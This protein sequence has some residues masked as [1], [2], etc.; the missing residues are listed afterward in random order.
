MNGASSNDIYLP[1]VL[2]TNM[3][4]SAISLSGFAYSPNDSVFVKNSKS[5]AFIKIASIVV[6]GGTTIT[7]PLPNAIYPSQSVSVYVQTI[8]GWTSNIA[9]IQP[10]SEFAPSN[11]NLSPCHI[12]GGLVTIGGVNF[13]ETTKVENV[14]IGETPC[15]D[16]T[17]LSTSPIV[18]VCQAPAGMGTRPVSI[19]I[20][21]VVK[22]D[23]VFS[24]L[25]PVINRVETNSNGELVVLCS[26]VPLTMEDGVSIT[27]GSSQ[28]VD[29]R[30]DQD[31]IHVP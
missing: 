25:A 5:G 29:F 30:I 1:W 4:A 31:G 24:Y 14:I 11:I 2:A 10:A 17:M 9:T 16:V 22:N 3:T 8:D 27:I 13:R 23:L 19:T 26:D 6:V 18:F 28:V 12:S 21:S 7:F 20:N 15:T